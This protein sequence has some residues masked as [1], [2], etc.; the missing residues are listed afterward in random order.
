M[1]DI[2]DNNNEVRKALMDQMRGITE[3]RC[4]REQDPD[5]STASPFEWREEVNGT[6]GT[7]LTFKGYASVVERGYNVWAP[8]IG[9]FTEIIDRGAFDETLKRNPDVSFKLNHEG[10]PM[11]KTSAGDL[12]LSADSTGL[13]AQASLDTDRADVKLMRQAIDAGHLSEMSFAFRVDRQ[14]WS[15]DGETRRITAANLAKGDVSV[16][17]WGANPMTAGLLSLRS[18]LTAHGVTAE[19]LETAFR[20]LTTFNETRSLDPEV[21]ALLITILTLTGIADSAVDLSQ[22]LLSDALGVENPDE[23]QDEV[24]EGADT[25]IDSDDTSRGTT[26]ILETRMTPALLRLKIANAQG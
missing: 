17:E 8:A 1:T 12:N 24:L 14:E 21:E 23:A 18:N 11:A 4:V 19:A 26:E 6:G 7:K 5:V 16:V 22:I 13:Y 9:D 3:T 2:L 15:E 10:L 25:D 20:A